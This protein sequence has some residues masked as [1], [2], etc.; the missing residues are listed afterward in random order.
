MERTTSRFCAAAFCTMPINCSEDIGN[1]HISSWRNRGRRSCVK[2]KSAIAMQ[3]LVQVDSKRKLELDWGKNQPSITLPGLIKRPVAEQRM[4]WASNARFHPL[5]E[6]CGVYLPWYQS[7]QLQ[8]PAITQGGLV[9]GRSNDSQENKETL[10]T[11]LTRNNSCSLNKARLNIYEVFVGDQF[12][13]GWMNMK[14]D[15]GHVYVELL[16][17]HV[18]ENFMKFLFKYFSA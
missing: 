18:F 16:I 1:R 7:F 4:N 3:K 13:E 5:Y 6:V 8:V 12:Y 2:N 15:H 14:V 11:H 9:F 17:V 10:T